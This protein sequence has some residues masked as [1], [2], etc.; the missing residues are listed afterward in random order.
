MSDVCFSPPALALLGVIASGVVAGFGLLYRN[1]VR[2]SDSEVA[3][4]RAELTEAQK[5]LRAGA[6]VM[7]EA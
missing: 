2:S 1:G 4:L 3:Y 5:R 6:S 7:D